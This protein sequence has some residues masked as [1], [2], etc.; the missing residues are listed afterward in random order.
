[1]KRRAGIC[2]RLGM[3]VLFLS[4]LRCLI[5]AENPS[6]DPQVDKAQYNLFNPTPPEF[7]RELSA[8]R[9]DKTESPYTVDAGHFQLETDL[10]NYTHDHQTS[11]N[12]DVRLDA[13]QF[14]NN[15]FKIG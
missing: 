9:P 11:G 15:N 14:A 12:E 8:D 10:A 6:L 2:I 1:M 5:A 7:M 3:L 13:F 4:G